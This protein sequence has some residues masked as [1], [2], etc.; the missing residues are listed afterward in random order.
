MLKVLSR[1]SMS[2]LEQFHCDRANNLGLETFNRIV[3]QVNS[4]LEIDPSLCIT[5][6]AFLVTFWIT[7]LERGFYFSVVCC[8]F[9][10][11]Q[12]MELLR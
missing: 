6:H 2:R 9:S 1:N 3:D 10:V 8:V 12:P 5:P 11:G 4:S 7:N